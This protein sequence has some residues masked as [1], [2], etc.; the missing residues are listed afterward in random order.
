MHCMGRLTHSQQNMALVEDVFYQG[1]KRPPPPPT[2]C[3]I[4]FL[5]QQC[6]ANLTSSNATLASQIRRLT[7]NTTKH[8]EEHN[9]M[10]SNIANILSLLQD[11]T[12][13]PQSSYQ[14]GQG[15]QG[16]RGGHG[17]YQQRYQNRQQHNA[18]AVHYCW[19]HTVTGGDY[20]VSANCENRKTGHRENATAL[21][22][23]G[24]STDGL[25]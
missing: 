24:G 5:S 19:S 2:S 17:N 13:R 11:T 18:P 12:I 7:K 15:N 20:H 25:E 21:N 4:P 6:I 22:R 14:G 23:M 9:S 10:K 3:R 16:G 8:K 1:C